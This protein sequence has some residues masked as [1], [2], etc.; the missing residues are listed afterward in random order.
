[1]TVIP[2]YFFFP[3]DSFSLSSS[4]SLIGISEPIGI[5]LDCGNS[6]EISGSG[7]VQGSAVAMQLLKK[8]TI[9]QNPAPG[10][11]TVIGALG[12]APEL[13]SAV[14]MRPYDYFIQVFTREYP[15]GTLCGKDR[16]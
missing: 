3:C 10:K 14:T 11:Y 12:V 1:M 6:D 7:S 16:R 8:I 2:P 4:F 13:G 5:Q 15:R 9:V